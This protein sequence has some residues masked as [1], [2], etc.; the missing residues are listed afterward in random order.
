VAAARGD[1]AQAVVHFEAALAIQPEATAIHYLLGMAHRALG[2]VERARSHLA[3][4]GERAA[5]QPDPLMDEVRALAT[6]GR[7]HLLRAG[8]ALEA[9]RVDEGIEELRRALAADPDDVTARVTLGA[10]LA[11][12]GERQQAKELFAEALRLEPGYAKAHYNLGLTL[13]GEGD[14]LR[15]IEHY[16]QALAS[17]PGH[18]R[19]QLQLA[20]ASLRLGRDR[21]A[22]EAYD[23][24]IELEPN[25]ESARLRQALILIRL[26]ADAEARDRLEVALVQLTE[27]RT[28]A[29][30][31]AR[32]LAASPDS[33]VRD[34]ARA[35]ALV[36]ELASGGGLFEGQVSFE[37][38]QTL[39]MAYAELGQFNR[40]VA[41][42]QAL[43]A[44]AERDHRVEGLPFLRDNLTRYQNGQPCRIPWPAND[45]IFA[46][47][48]TAT[49]G[50]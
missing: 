47:L 1:F 29:H 6:G 13:A 36:T 32:L 8:R 17:D 14:D 27:A 46:Q 19:A 37:H 31:L 50:T 16:R 42:Q 21:E 41:L 26:G 45:P 12:R 4:R 22:V 20:A 48:P 7:S 10:I 39:A 40:A 38:G 25:D 43:L 3:L 24:F 28:L 5:S 34:G 49:D 9:D 30:A 11:Q 23:R 33:T 35:L 44:A 18:E 2:D 15:A